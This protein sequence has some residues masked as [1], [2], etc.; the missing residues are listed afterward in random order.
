ME[1]SPLSSERSW[2]IVS[3]GNFD[4]DLTSPI[5]QQKRPFGGGSLTRHVCRVYVPKTLEKA[6]GEPERQHGVC[7]RPGEAPEPP[8]FLGAS[9]VFARG[10][11]YGTDIG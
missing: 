4:P 9:L 5:Q 10:H 6:G 11:A 2:S 3:Y 1:P 8:R 7:L